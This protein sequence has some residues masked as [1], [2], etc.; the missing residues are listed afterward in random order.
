MVTRSV[1]PRSLID[2]K[3]FAVYR[4]DVRGRRSPCWW[5]RPDED[6][7]CCRR[8]PGRR[9]KAPTLESSPSRRSASETVCTDKLHVTSYSPGGANGP[10]RRSVQS[11]QSALMRSWAPNWLG[12]LLPEDVHSLRQSASTP[13]DKLHRI[14]QMAPMTRQVAG[15]VQR[16]LRASETVCT[17]QTVTPRPSE[18]P[19]TQNHRCKRRR[20]TRLQKNDKNV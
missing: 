20:R 18:Q 9:C 19:A 16:S 7:R 3:L 13:S 1:W 12:S 17:A 4:E 6:R 2:G 11:M 14:R 15:P 5:S 8:L 10:A